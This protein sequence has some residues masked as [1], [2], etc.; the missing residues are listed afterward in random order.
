MSQTEQFKDADDRKSPDVKG[1]YDNDTW[2]SCCFTLSKSA[3][4]YIAAYSISLMV[5]LFSFYM[6]SSEH[7]SQNTA[8]W[9]SMVSA[10]A[11]Q[12]L[13]S[14]IYNLNNK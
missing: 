4:K 1:L 13:P 14:P 12:Y 9:S 5:L 10:I 3:V 11:A 2:R 7:G 6:L 8:L